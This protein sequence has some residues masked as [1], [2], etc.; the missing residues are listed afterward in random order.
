MLNEIQRH[1]LAML[2]NLD[3]MKI[4]TERGL[5]ECDCEDEKAKIEALDHMATEL[6]RT[7][8]GTLKNFES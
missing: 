5:A 6:L 7:I 2:A 4:A 8:E 3:Q 1:L